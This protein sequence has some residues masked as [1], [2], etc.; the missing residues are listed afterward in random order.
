MF[1]ARFIA[2]GGIIKPDYALKLARKKE[3]LPDIGRMSNQ[4]PS[5]SSG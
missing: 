4:S 1:I 3:I 2:G 5:K